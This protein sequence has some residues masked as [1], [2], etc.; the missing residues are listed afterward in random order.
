MS[1]KLLYTHVNQTVVYSLLMSIKLFYTY[2]NQN[3]K[4]VKFDRLLTKKEKRKQ[5]SCR[6][7]MERLNKYLFKRFSSIHLI[8]KVH[9]PPT[10]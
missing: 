8:Q 10:L 2:A 5:S 6:E 3:G 4:T 9:S 1:I 7:R